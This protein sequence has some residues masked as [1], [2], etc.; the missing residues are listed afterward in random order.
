MPTIWERLEGADAPLDPLTADLL[1][2]ARS[3]ERAARRHLHDRAATVAVRRAY[4]A[5]LGAVQALLWEGRRRRFRIR[6]SAHAAFWELFARPDVGLVDPDLHRWLLET[7]ALCGRDGEDPAPRVTLEDAARSLE[8][9]QA[10]FVA[11]H[12]LLG[13]R[14]P[15]SDDLR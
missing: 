15:A 1:T 7:Y 2:Q 13:L 3:A 9:T 14:S 6:A 10:F 5:M 8:R 4:H 12:M 11:V